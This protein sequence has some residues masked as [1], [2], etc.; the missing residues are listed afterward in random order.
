MH[1]DNLS[2]KSDFSDLNTFELFEMSVL[3]EIESFNKN[4]PIDNNFSINKATVSF[5]FIILDI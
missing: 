4:K 1:E 2:T 3:K 5:F